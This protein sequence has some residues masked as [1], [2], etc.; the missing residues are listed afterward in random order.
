MR[1]SDVVLSVVLELA[2]RPDALTSDRIE[3]VRKELTSILNDLDKICDKR[4][5]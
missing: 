5:D 2:G 4:S 3:Q 1:H